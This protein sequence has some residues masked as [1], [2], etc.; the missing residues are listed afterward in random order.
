MARFNFYLKKSKA[1]K[2]AP[3]DLTI[4]YSGKRFRF[5]T[6]ESILSKYWNS[7]T[8]RAKQSFTEAPEFNQ[9]LTN[10]ETDAKD[11]FRRYQNDH[12]HE[13]PSPAEYKKLL[14]A[15]IKGTK[16]GIPTTLIEF[17][18]YFIEKMRRQ[19]IT[20]KRN[21]K[22]II[23]GSYEQTLNCLRDYAGDK[24]KRVDFDTMDSEFYND[25]VRYLETIKII[26]DENGKK[27]KKYGFSLN[28][29]GK[30]IKNLKCILNE[31][32]TPE[33][34]VNKFTS[35]KRFKVDAEEVESIYLNEG[36][37]Q[38]LYDL[39]L[40]SNTRL[41]RVR[42]LFLVGCWTGLR[43]SDF[44][45]IKA[46]DIHGEYI[47]MKTQKTGE[48]VVI[49]IH[50]TV[51]AIMTKYSDYPNSLP[52]DISNVNMNV[53]LK[54]LAGMLDIFKVKTDTT[55]TR[56]GM[57][58]TTSKLKCDMITTHCA[59][60]SFATNM[61]KAGIPTI[62]IMKVTGH[63]TERAFLTYIKVTPDEHARI[64]MGYFQ[65]QNKLRVV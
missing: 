42:D 53:Y 36:E 19:L 65:K 55:K 38:A 60:R 49:P 8:Q 61:F 2:P 27:I 31:A 57:R 30:H 3:I 9:R 48:K 16:S 10:I 14:E 43:F 18:E 51:K 41:D 15:A 40:T 24:N 62:T 5:Y 20:E 7:E 37:L 4:T 46:K 52:P 28:T 59:R 34:G 22:S 1:T 21:T 54:E 35:Y 6:R 47:H 33:M 29:I 56:A 63:K 26:T 23:A 13:K 50:W 32:A 45:N 17:G 64:M 12:N 44:T 25:F 39:D 58:V 11:I